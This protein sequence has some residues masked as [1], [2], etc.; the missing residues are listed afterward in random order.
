MDVFVWTKSNYNCQMTSEN[1][2]TLAEYSLTIKVF[3]NFPTRQVSAWLS[4]SKIPPEIS[5]GPSLVSE[6]LLA[7]GVTLVSGLGV[8]DAII[9]PLVSFT[10]WKLLPLSNMMP[11]YASLVILTLGL[12]VSF[13]IPYHFNNFCAFASYILSPWLNR[14]WS[15]EF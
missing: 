3:H 1:L 10:C 11:S 2:D 4:S 5:V 15:T 9:S 13:R 7:S 6:I 14:K 12:T 8:Y